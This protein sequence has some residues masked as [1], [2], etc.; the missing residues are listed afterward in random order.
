MPGLQFVIVPRIYRNLS[1]EE[2]IAQTEPAFEDIV[3]LLTT[4]TNGGPQTSAK[5]TSEVHR[6]EGDDRLDTMLRMNEEFL[7]RD[8]GDGFPMLPATRS[9]VDELL[10]ACGVPRDTL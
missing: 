9:A 2:S 5:D 8:W 4:N 3:S 10:K 7:N 1:K 6:F